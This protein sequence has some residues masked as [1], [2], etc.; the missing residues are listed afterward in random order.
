MAQAIT[1][2]QC[3]KRLYLIELYYT[4]GRSSLAVRNINNYAK[5]IVP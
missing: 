3:Y 1:H 2:Q 4:L 5:T